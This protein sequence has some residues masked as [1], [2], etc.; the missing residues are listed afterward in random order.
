[1]RKLIFLLIV[2][3]VA[4]CLPAQP[5]PPSPTPPI[6]ATPA[7][8][9]APPTTEERDP[10]STPAAAQPPPTP[11]PAASD[12]LGDPYYPRLGNGGYDAQHYTLDLSA[13]MPS[14]A[15]SATL[16]LTARATADLPAF[17]LDFQGLTVRAVLVDGQS[18]VY[19]RTD[20]ELTIV[21]A[22]SIRSGATFTTT[23]R[24]DG[25]PQ[26]V[27]D[28]AIPIPLG[29]TRYDSGVYI[30]SEPS[31]ASAWYP[32]NDHPRDKATYTFRVTVAKP[33]VVAANGQLQQMRD[34][35]DTRTYVWKAADPLASYLVTV[36]IAEFVEEVG[37]GP[38]GLP[39][40]NFYPPAVAANARRVFAP[41]AEM[42]DYFDDLFGPFPFEAYGVVVADRDLGYAL[43]TQTLS[44]FGRDLAS[45]DPADVQTVVAHELAHQWF[46]DS[47][48]P[49]NWQDIWLNE[50]FASYAEWLW[51][52][53]GAGTQT[54]D[55]IIREAYR[56]LAARAPPPP[57]APPRDDLF[58]GGVY[59]RGGLTLHALRLRVGDET[60]FKILRAYADRYRYGAAR[61]ADF[62]AVAEEVGG[63]E[64]DSLFDGWLYAEQL[65]ELPELGLK[66]EK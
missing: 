65:P 48:S 20:H 3:I 56:D 39:I 66:P 1:M 11:L 44:L 45:A 50:G 33:Y 31:G 40:R 4:G 7:P 51:I 17:N 55:A 16:V 27:Q 59:R 5:A 29:W 9:S 24:Y 13:D 2:L 32:V 10:S 12:G 42:I 6:P 63:Q 54:R 38:G 61:T 25:V 23:V 43:E 36:N 60:F 37:Q 62:I 52:E 64:L 34:N 19:R 58:N 26:L 46:G 22:A 15:I 8:I 14:G 49:A 21:P 41:T 28:R 18:A 53:H 35:G 30:V 57:G 47:V